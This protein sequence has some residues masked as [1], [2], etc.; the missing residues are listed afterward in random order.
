MGGKEA[1]PR[2]PEGWDSPRTEAR[3]AEVGPGLIQSKL[4]FASISPFTLG[5]C[6]RARDGCHGPS[7][8]PGPRLWLP[9]QGQEHS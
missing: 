5:L 6:T 8:C 4:P 2:R 7:C 3:A 1:G 9:R